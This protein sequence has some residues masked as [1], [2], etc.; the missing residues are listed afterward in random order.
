MTQTAQSWQWYDDNA[1]IYEEM[2]PVT[3]EFGRQL[4]DYADPVPGARLL[5]VGAGRGA[6]VRV[7]LSRG[8]VV[9]AVDAAPG[10]VARLR[11]DFPT[12]SAAQMD[13]HRLD[14][15]DS[16]Y[17]VVTAG[18]VIDLLSDPAEALAE[19][20]R[21]LKPGGVFALSTP[22]PLPYRERWQWLVDLAKE[23]YPTTVREDPGGPTDMDVDRLLTAAGF[24]GATSKTFEYPQPISH[25]AALWDLFS[26]REQTAVSAGWIEWM[27]PDQAVEFRRRFL[28]G[29]EQM[30]ANGGIAMDRYMFLHRAQAPAFS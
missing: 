19:V 11:T 10:M 30:H 25:A 20:R 16:C 1:D 6:V 14:F 5:D 28:A 23:F 21:V 12:I 8:C 13:A 3:L 27:P 9:T 7:A 24:V 15:P 18:F 2:D 29:A 26:S 17:D 22:G 4:L